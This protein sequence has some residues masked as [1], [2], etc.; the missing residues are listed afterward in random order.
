MPRSIA[1]PMPAGDIKSFKPEI[2]PGSSAGSAP[3]DNRSAYVEK[4]PLLSNE[5]EVSLV[6]GA[7]DWGRVKLL[8]YW[9]EKPGPATTTFGARPIMN[10][11][12]LGNSP[13]RNENDSL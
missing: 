7:D 10:F 6:H 11:E 4:M 1:A 5:Y 12:I 8:V 3:V 13:L 9:V 2:C